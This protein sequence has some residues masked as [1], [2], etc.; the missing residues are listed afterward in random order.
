MLACLPLFVH[1]LL[2]AP[3]R[4]PLLVLFFREKSTM[5][6]YAIIML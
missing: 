1:W 3:H 5:Q 2:V 4:S 6:V